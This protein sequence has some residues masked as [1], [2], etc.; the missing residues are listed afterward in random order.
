MTPTS[1]WFG[2]LLEFSLIERNTFLNTLNSHHRACMH[3]PADHTQMV[4]RENCFDSIQ[5][6]LPLILQIEGSNSW[7][8]IFEYE[9]P[10]ERGR[11]PDVVL[12]AG[13]KI[14][15]LEYKDYKISTQAHIDQVAAYA[16]DIT[17]YHAAS[18]NHPVFPILV[19][20]QASK[21]K[22]QVDEV[23]I[24]SP[25]Y[26]PDVIS[27]QNQELDTETID[28][29]SWVLADYSPL[30]SLINA[31]RSIFQHDPLPYIR[32]AYSA[33]IPTTIDH[34]VNYAKQ[35]QANHEHHIAL[36]TGVPG[37]GKTLVG[38]K[39]VYENHFN[40]QDAQRTAIFLSGNG[41]LVKVLQYA[42]KSSVFVQDVHGFLRQYGGSSSFVPDEHICVFDEAQRAWDSERVRQK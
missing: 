18:H 35:A 33:G 29:Q 39:F 40:D 26:L 4:A 7:S 21:L 27:S 14:F 6:Y 9:L 23:L 36:V 25:D 11:R 37:A 5:A 2:T 15:I 38:L 10:R 1:G 32:R 3:M 34:L 8:L 12:L 31:A 30:P 17:N 42:L 22:M 28:L 20:T 16:R 13:S 41:P 24:T 19:L